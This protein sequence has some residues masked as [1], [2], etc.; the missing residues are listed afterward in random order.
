MNSTELLELFR[1]EV[2]DTV[3]PYLWSDA[4]IYRYI[5]EAQK[6]FCRKT[7]G[8]E[9]SRTSAVTQIA[10]AAGT[11]WYDTSKLILKI[12]SA[13]RNDTGADIPIYGVEKAP[14]AGVRFDGRSGPLKAFVSGLDK[15]TLRAWPVPSESV[16]VTLSV[17]RLPLMSITDAGDQNLEIDEQHHPHL[18]LWVKHR[19][20][21]KEDAETF[22]ARKAAD[23]EGRFYEYCRSAR[24]EQERARR[25]ASTVV[26]GGI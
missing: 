3:K 5:D 24:I 4:L 16:G 21:G 19:A 1:E 7:E 13:T 22:D 23:F 25:E 26:Y 15:N 10:V 8:I 11:S 17:F 20:Y 18:L 6:M 9:D 2:A 12:R 14:N